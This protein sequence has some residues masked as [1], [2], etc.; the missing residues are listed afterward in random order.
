MKWSK[1]QQRLHSEEGQTGSL[2]RLSIPAAVLDVP[3]TS[4]H[5]ALGRC[6]S[7]I[8]S[9]AYLSQKS[10]PPPPPPASRLHGGI[11]LTAAQGRRP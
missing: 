1:E 3:C 10:H 11:F 9:T 2:C 8:V 7:F 6:T 5:T 4:L